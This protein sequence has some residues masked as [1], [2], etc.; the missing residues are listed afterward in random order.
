MKY[1]CIRRTDAPVDCKRAIG[2][3]LLLLG[4]DQYFKV[5]TMRAGLH[6]RMYGSLLHDVRVSS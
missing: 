2:R 4:V 5:S 1:D 3:V 6:A